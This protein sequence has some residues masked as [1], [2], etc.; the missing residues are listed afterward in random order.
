MRI[1]AQQVFD[2]YV[3]G[4]ATGATFYT[5]SEFED[6]LARCDALALQ[7]VANNVTGTSPEV[8]VSLETSGDGINW[9]PYAAVIDAT[10][11][12]ANATTVASGAWGFQDD[13]CLRLV[14]LAV[15]LSGSSS[16][17]AHVRVYACGRGKPHFLLGPKTARYGACEGCGG[18]LPSSLG[19]GGPAASLASARRNAAPPGNFLPGSGVGSLMEKRKYETTV[20]APVLTALEGAVA[21]AIMESGFAGGSTHSKPGERGAGGGQGPSKEDKEKATERVQ[22]NQEMRQ[23]YQ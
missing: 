20:R 17:G 5:S 23:V 21:G 13:P 22:P 2:A 11:L 16:P 19:T 12:Q 7:L 9:S 15:A 6:L 8:E 4:G 14:R 10:S 1:F 3:T 18:S